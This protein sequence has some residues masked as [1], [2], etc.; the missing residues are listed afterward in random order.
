MA[1]PKAAPA[2]LTTVSLV[3][4]NNTRSPTES[5]RI[6]MVYRLVRCP[7]SLSARCQRGSGYV[8]DLAQPCRNVSGGDMRSS[9]RPAA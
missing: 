1:V 7:P 5:S 6:D 4:A 8:S 9:T 2:R 3:A